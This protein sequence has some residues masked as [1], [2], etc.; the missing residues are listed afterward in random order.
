MSYDTDRAL[1]AEQAVLGA[2]LIDEE[3]VGPIL[4]AV[5]PRDFYLDAHRRVFLAFRKAFS[6]GG[7]ADLV[8]VLN[9]L[10][11]GEDKADVDLGTFLTELMK[12]TP[13]AAT[14]PTYAKIVK[15][16]AQLRR[17]KSLA[18]NLEDAAGL[19]DAAT[20]VS[21]IN[22]AMAGHQRVQGVTMA[23]ALERFYERQKAEPH[24]IPWGLPKLD[25]HLFV[26]RGKFVILGGSPSDGKTALA[27]T[28]AWEQS[29]TLRVGFFSLET[30]DEDLMNRLVSTV[31]QI[32]M[33]RIMRHTVRDEDYAALAEKAQAITE[34]NLLLFDVGAITA[35]E[36]LSLA[37]AYRLDVIYIDYIQLLSGNP[38]ESSYERVTRTSKALH[39]GA[40]NT[41]I[42]VVAL[43]QLNRSDTPVPKS[44]KAGAGPVEVQ[45]PRM[46]ALRESGQLEQD[47]DVILMI[48][49]L[50][51][52]N[53][54]D[55]ARGLNIEKNKTGVVGF[56]RLDFDGATQTFQEHQLTKGEHYQQVHRDIK[57]AARGEYV[58]AGD[59]DPEWV[60]TAMMAEELPD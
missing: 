40:Q 2:M 11:T 49:R 16:T 29:R 42:N 34:H 37:L 41:G 39:L 24:Y 60:Q 48:Y 44:K 58:P 26:D 21:K 1:E 13:T 10:R 54:D 51:P 33:A 22:E 46:S 6:G 55:P 31:A 59:P 20:V 35:E 57:R 30:G 12:L 18:G 7:P 27:L 19:D 36:V 23:Q 52:N 38:K 3:S 25:Q 8:T 45:A 17:L 32:Q 28:M 43:S 15:D 47:A 9:E 50:Y 14:W 5:D 53:K 56:I 4:S